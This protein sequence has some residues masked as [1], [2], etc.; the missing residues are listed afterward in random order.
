MRIAYGS[1]KEKQ[2]IRRYLSVRPSL[3]LLPDER[4]VHYLE[5]FMEKMQCTDKKVFLCSSGSEA[6]E[7]ALKL[8]MIR[9]GTKDGKFNKHTKT[10]SFSGAFHGRSCAAL[11]TSHSK[12]IHKKYIHTF[13]WAKVDFPINSV[14]EQTTLE[15]I[16]DMLYKNH[17][18]AVTIEPIQCEGGDR[19]AS[20]AFYSQ[21]RE[22][23][24]IHDVPLIVD[25]V[26]TGIGATGKFWAHQY[27]NLNKEP[28]MITFGKKSR[29]CGVLFPK[30]YDEFIEP[31]QI[32][33]TWC[34]NPI[35]LIVG[36]KILNDTN[37]SLLKNITNNGYI[38]KNMFEKEVTPF[39][40]FRG[41][42]HILAFDCLNERYRDE[43]VRELATRGVIVSPCG[44][45]SIRLRPTLDFTEK[46]FKKF[47][48]II[49]DPRLIF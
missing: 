32:Y 6:N 5:E 26:Q 17:I 19:R 15:H 48:N 8:A 27:W 20:D 36:N 28:D 29:V 44:E 10:I 14:Q 33:N 42:G 30:E 43:L 39:A 23:C 38:F 9:K 11:T 37:D 40:N 34:G 24:L 41:R 16:Y 46:K 35:E 4:Y 3:G 31:H 22:I 47:I 13:P 45:V 49:K 2:D 18:F 21:L 25:E 12:F 1:T 7:I